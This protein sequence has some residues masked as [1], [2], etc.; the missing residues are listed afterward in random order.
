MRGHSSLPRSELNNRLD[1]SC[2]CEREGKL[3]TALEIAN[4]VY[5][6]VRS[7]VHNIQ[8]LQRGGSAGSGLT[9]LSST[10]SGESLS[11]VPTDDLGLL[12]K[13]L[14]QRGDIQKAMAADVE[15]YLLSY[16]ES[17]E[18]MKTIRERADRS[19]RGS[20]TD[21]QSFSRLHRQLAKI[22]LE[23]KNCT[24]AVY[25]FSEELAM[26]LLDSDFSSREM[27]VSFISQMRYT[28]ESYSTAAREDSLHFCEMVSEVNAK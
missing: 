8:E 19:D 3:D 7:Y 25:H 6:T 4:N 26:F 20:F 12:A 21:F 27:T 2:H 28:L 17:H 5:D 15:A 24:K 22:Y 23:Q 9:E 11:S 18:I 10:S 13:T 1:E 16:E 14:Q